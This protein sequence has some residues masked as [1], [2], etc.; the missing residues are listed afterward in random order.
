MSESSGPH[1]MATGDSYRLGSVGRTMV[2]CTTRIANPDAD[3]NGEIVMGGRHITMGYLNQKAMTEETLDSDGSMHT[4]D[5]G[6]L[7]KD[8]FLFIT[9]R[10]KEILITAGGENVAPVPIED[11]IKSELPVVS[12]AVVLGD[13]L[14]FLSVL[15]TLK[16]RLETIFICSFIFIFIL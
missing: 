13:K 8:G 10:L 11:R 16:V 12:Q 9:G 7:D 3:G 4:G 2:G 5:V 14:K 15:L 6:R 1:C